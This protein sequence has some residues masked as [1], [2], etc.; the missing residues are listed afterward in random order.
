MCAIACFCDSVIFSLC[1]S[2]FCATTRSS[3]ALPNLNKNP[4]QHNAFYISC[5]RLDTCERSCDVSC[6]ILHDDMWNDHNA[7]RLCK[8]FKQLENGVW[9]WII[10]NPLFLQRVSLLCIACKSMLELTNQVREMGKQNKLLPSCA[11]KTA[12]IRR[13]CCAWLFLACWLVFCA[14]LFLCCTYFLVHM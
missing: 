12:R 7:S 5:I 2:C 8:A 11:Q 3:M 1:W 13:P 14:R 9:K 10:N 6:W 4:D